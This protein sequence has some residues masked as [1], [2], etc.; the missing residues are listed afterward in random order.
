MICLTYGYSGSI[1][2]LDPYITY[3]S[4]FY[5]NCLDSCLLHIIY[6][7]SLIYIDLVVLMLGLVSRYATINCFWRLEMCFPNI[8]VP[9]SSLFI[10]KVYERFTY[11]RRKSSVC[12][13][14][15]LCDDI[16]MCLGPQS[17][18]LTDHINK[19]CKNRGLKFFQINVRG[20]Q[21]NF[22]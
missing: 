4:W 19:L 10:G 17:P 15:L 13:L 20:L 22:D 6:Y 5:R 2:Y 9:N 12:L 16:E 7:F 3:F 1:H 21:G 11:W 18:S 14:L 8:L